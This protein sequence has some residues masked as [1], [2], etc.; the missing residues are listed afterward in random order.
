M[1]GKRKSYDGRVGNILPGNILVTSPNVPY[2]YK[3]RLMCRVRW[4]QGL[5]F[6]PDDPLFLPQPFNKA[7]PHLALIMPPSCDPQDKYY[8][9]WARPTKA[10]FVPDDICPGEVG[11]GRLESQFH[12]G[13]KS[14]AKQ[15]LKQI[16]E[17]TKDNFVLEGSANLHR[18]LDRLQILSTCKELFLR[19]A[20]AQR[21]L[22]ELHARLRY[23]NEKWETR[24][25]EAKLHKKAPDIVDVVGAFTEDLDALDALYYAG[26]PVWFVR[27]TSLIPKPRIDQVQDFICEDDFQ[28]ITLHRGEVLDCTDAQPSHKVVF[29]GLPNNLDRYVSMGRFIRSQFQSPLLLGAGELRIESELKHTSVMATRSIG[30]HAHRFEPC[31]YRFAFLPLS[32]VINLFRSQKA[33]WKQ[34]GLQYLPTPHASSDA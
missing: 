2:L 11:L 15:L 7:V 5:H 32:S 28:K 29:T 23:I 9:A 30:I 22:I 26:I 16:P 21:Q 1:V 6:G 34:T 10:E 8:Y 18:L 3:P 24:F 25:R 19:V 4:R 12:K 13:L 14:L 17:N 31:E 27:H 20:C 33:F